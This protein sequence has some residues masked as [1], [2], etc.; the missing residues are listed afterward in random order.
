METQSVHKNKI[1]YQNDSAFIANLDNGKMRFGFKGL[2][3]KDVEPFEVPATFEN[4]DVFEDFVS[5]CFGA[6]LSA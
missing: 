5:D 1:I 4:D 3:C 2:A 6:T